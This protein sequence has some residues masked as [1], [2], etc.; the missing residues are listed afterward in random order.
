MSRCLVPVVLEILV[1]SGAVAVAAP[2]VKHPNLL[3][4]ADEIKQ[5][6]AK[7]AKYPWAAAALEKTKEHALNGPPHENSFVNQALYYTFTGDT[8]ESRSNRGCRSP[9]T[10]SSSR[11]RPTGRVCSSSR[12]ARRR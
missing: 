3:L 9:P 4:N 11:T 2:P 10:G 5:V 6:K 1:L 8:R 7:I 12:R